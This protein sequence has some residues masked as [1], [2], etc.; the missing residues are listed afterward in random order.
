[1]R[2]RPFVIGLLIIMCLTSCAPQPQSNAALAQTAS[3]PQSVSPALAPQTLDTATTA[4]S[5]TPEPAFTSSPTATFTSEPFALQFTP[6][7]TDTP[8]P[9]LVLPTQAPNQKAL[10][11]W[12]GVPTYLAD[13]QPGFDFRVRFD[14]DVWALTADQFGFPALGHRNIPTCVIS[15]ASG[16][17][18]PLNVTVEQEV[19]KVGTVRYQISTAYLNGVKQFVNYTGGD[20]T[21]LTAFQVSFQDQVDQCISDA[22]T[23]LATLTSVS[24]SQ[25]TPTMTP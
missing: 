21:I 15:P 24:A 25:A 13:S 23:V 8:L 17:G 12:D 11:I 19:R 5:D 9:T 4:P 2:M 16:R 7:P 18:L 6:V 22:E 10:Q 3:T 14:P 1:M 20:G